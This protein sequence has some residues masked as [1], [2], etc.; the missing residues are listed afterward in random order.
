MYRTENSE[1]NSDNHITYLLCFAI[2]TYVVSGHFFFFGL[3]ISKFDIFLRWGGG[4]GVRSPF[5]G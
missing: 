3:E 5:L 2:S 1:D 4:G